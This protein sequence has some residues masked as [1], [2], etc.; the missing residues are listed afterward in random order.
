MRQNHHEQSHEGKPMSHT[1][2]RTYHN[3]LLARA[4]ASILEGNA[5]PTFLEDE[6]VGAHH[7]MSIGVKL[8]VPSE[9]FQE[10]LAILDSIVTVDDSDEA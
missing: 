5:I 3:A 4:D 7:G 1:V 2:V 6:H 8:I 10:A 9:R